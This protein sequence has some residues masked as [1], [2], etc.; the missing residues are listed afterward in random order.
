[1][2]APLKGQ[3]QR[4][5]EGT[6]LSLTA[7]LFVG[8]LSS[9]MGRDKATIEIGGV[10]L[11]KR[12]LDILRELRPAAI[13]VSARVRPSWCPPDVELVLDQPPSQ[14]PLTGLAAALGQMRNTHL[15][16]LAIDLPCITVEEL[17]CLWKQAHPGRGVI[18]V[19]GEHLEPLCAFYPVEAGARAVA[20]LETDDVSLHHL[21]KTLIADD[22]LVEYFLTEKE[23]LFFQNI[24]SPEDLRSLGTAR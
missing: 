13:Q 1:M 18:P 8:G 4:S 12:Q 24:N 15:V 22:R 10:P 5:G 19:N 21:A 17:R 3:E 9:R 7:V 20:A 11:W 6:Q 2:K 23:K 16:A 14:G